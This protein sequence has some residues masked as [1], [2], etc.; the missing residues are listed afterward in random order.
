MAR[1]ERRHTDVQQDPDRQSRRD[2]LPHH[3]HLPE[4]GIRSVA[5][6]SEADANAQ[7]VLLADEA[8]AIGGPRPQE[9][10]LR[11]DAIIEVAL[12]SGAQ[13]IHPGY[14]FLSENADF[15]DAVVA[16]GLVF[17]GPGA[18]SMRKMGSKAGAKDLMSAHGVPVVPGYT[19]EDQDPALLQREADRIGYPLMIKAA[20]GGGG[21]GMRLVQAAGEFAASLESCQRESKN[22]FGRDRV[23]LERYVQQPRHIEFQVFADRHGHT[24]HLGEREC[25][26]QRRYQK[27]IEESPSP[28]LTPERRLQMGEAAVQAARAIDYVNAGTVE[29]IVGA[30][31]DFYF[32]EINTRLQVEHPVTEMV[33]GLDLV[34]W[35]LRVAA[36][37]HLPLAQEAITHRGHAMEVRLYA[38]DPERNFL[39][40][41]GRLDSLV[42]PKPSAHLRLDGGVVEGDTVTIFYDPMIAKLIVWDEDRPRALARM[43]DALAGCEIVSLKS[44]VEFLE[45]LIRHPV[46]V[47]GR[48]D[49]GY[50]DKHLDEVLPDPQPPSSEDIAAAVAACLLAR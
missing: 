27:I 21:K 37:E 2:R 32:M 3:P 23:L 4:L 12:A 24:V 41:S 18:A 10:Y 8:Y 22:A 1:H 14:G 13:A 50:L 6:F 33:T 17:I 16:A 20:H 30:D 48:I 46:V 43:R 25:S 42:L 39:P 5:V 35:Q 11:G 49:T 36:G 26:A 9:S 44:N 7:H 38:E 31:G 45:K 29:F 34:E 28:F 19:G 40:G 15:A 47:E